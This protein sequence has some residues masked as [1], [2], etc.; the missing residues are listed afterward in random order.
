[1]APVCQLI[2]RAVWQHASQAVEPC[3]QCVQQRSENCRTLVLRTALLCLLAISTDECLITFFAL[4]MYCTSSPALMH[5][6]STLNFFVHS[7]VRQE[8]PENEHLHPPL[9][10]TVVDWRAFGRS[11]L[12]GNHIINNLKAFKYSPPASHTVQLHKPPEVTHTPRPSLTPEPHSVKGNDC[13]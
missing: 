13:F 4:T 6:L 12:V 10:I 1:M 5:F 2:S 7:V 3:N 11:T 8:L 9:S